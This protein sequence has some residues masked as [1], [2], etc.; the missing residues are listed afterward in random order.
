MSIAGARYVHTNLMTTDWRRLAQFYI[1][2]FGCEVVPPVRDY[3]NADLAALT[4]LPGA[5]LRGVHLRLPGYPLG[6]P[7]LEIYDYAE[8]VEGAPP[9]VNRPGFGHI[10]FAVDDVHAARRAVLDA[11]GRAVGEVVTL[12]TAAGTHVTCCY[13]TD[14]EGNILE[15]QSW[16]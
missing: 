14:P 5:H 1:D 15:L 2:L 9:A 13:V 7:T 8:M 16:D 12:T 11:G 10:A 3:A 4:G 6:G